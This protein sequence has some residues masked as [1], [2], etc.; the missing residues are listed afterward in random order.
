MNQQAAR[1]HNGVN[2]TICCREVK[3][4]QNLSSEISDTFS[5]CRHD[6]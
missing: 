2:M 5:V 1:H 3:H 6:L 4:L